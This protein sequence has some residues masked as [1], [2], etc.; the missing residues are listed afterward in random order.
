MLA[1][2]QIQSIIMIC[3]GGFLL[4]SGLFCKYKTTNC[5]NDANIF[6]FKFGCARVEKML[7]VLNLLPHLLV[8]DLMVGEVA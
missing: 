3:P 1:V 5:R 8:G 4:R 6:E 7:Y 2:N